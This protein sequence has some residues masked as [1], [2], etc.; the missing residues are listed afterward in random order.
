M[1]AQIRDTRAA[2]ELEDFLAPR[3][4]ELQRRLLRRLVKNMQKKSMS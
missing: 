4:D 1:A 2:S 3:M